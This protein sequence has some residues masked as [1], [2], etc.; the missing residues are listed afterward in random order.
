L[1]V[2]VREERAD[3][4]LKARRFRHCASQVLAYRDVA[5]SFANSKIPV[6]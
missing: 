4:C 3:V 6:F 1:N 5:V 2:S